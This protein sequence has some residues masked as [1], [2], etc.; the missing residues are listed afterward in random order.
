MSCREAGGPEDREVSLGKLVQFDKR[1]RSK[2]AKTSPGDAT[3][4]IF[5]GVRYERGSTTLPDKGNTPAKPGRK[6]G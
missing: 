3:I 5:T 1:P 4:I 2:T 6:R